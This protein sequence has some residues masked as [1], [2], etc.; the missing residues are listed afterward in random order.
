MQPPVIVLGATN[1]PNDI[2]KSF[3]RRMPFIVEVPLPNEVGRYDILKKM[4]SKEI[5]ENDVDLI[6]LATMTTNYSGSDLKGEFE[7][8][9]R[10]FLQFSHLKKKN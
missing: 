8:Y 1:R 9:E 4:L 6:N 3:L 5:L 2:D 10:K 7:V